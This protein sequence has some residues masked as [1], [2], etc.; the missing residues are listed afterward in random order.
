MRALPVSAKP[1][2]I[3]AQIGVHGDRPTPRYVQ[4]SG[5]WSLHVYLYHGELRIGDERQAIR[6]GT[7]ALAP[8][9]CTL[10]YHLNGRSEHFYALFNAAPVPP[11]SVPAM[12]P[13]GEQRE[14]VCAEFREMIAVGATNKLRAEV[15]LW[16]LLLFASEGENA[17]SATSQPSHPAVQRALRLIEERLSET[18]DIATLADD[19][20]LS[21]SHLIRLFRAHIQ[22][23]PVQYIA[24]R[25]MEIAA[26][27]IKHT[28]MP[29][30]DVAQ[31]VG[32]A[33]LHQ[34]NKMFRRYTGLAPRAWRG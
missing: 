30:K 34:F 12:I 2:L 10:E 17:G 32:I 9:D 7:M 24:R 8:P 6:P 29:V 20:G 22:C 16:D 11:V 26:N 15:K 27:L 3:V 13:L 5:L 4:E 28:S 21:H 18:I 19:T 31:Q 14:K 1:T 33:D 25:R 23:P